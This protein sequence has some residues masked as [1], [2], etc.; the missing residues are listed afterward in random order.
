MTTLPR[1]AV[2][3]QDAPSRPRRRTAA[4]LREL[5]TRPAFPVGAEVQDRDAA[6]RDAELHAIRSARGAD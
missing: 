5:L 6:R 3:R 2:S 4:L 1:S